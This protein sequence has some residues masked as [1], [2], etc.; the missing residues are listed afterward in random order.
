M[1]TMTRAQSISRLI[2]EKKKS[3]GS[4]YA[5]FIFAARRFELDPA[6]KVTAKTLLDLIPNNRVQI[7]KWVGDT[8]C[9]DMCVTESDKDREPDAD[10]IPL[11]RLRFR[12]SR[13]LA[14]AVLLVP[15]KMPA[16]IGFAYEAV[17]H[18]ND[19]YAVQMRT[20]CRANH[21]GF[22]KAIEAMPEDDRTWFVEHIFNPK[23]C[24]T[25]A[26]PEAD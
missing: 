21:E 22:T 10:I 2:A 5:Q 25:I 7:E 26:F 6:N 14:R 18:P 23:G 1:A 12:L 3:G 8:L 19:D 15:D 17:Q 24:R 4:Y 9:T 20:V 11:C 16:Y 13:D